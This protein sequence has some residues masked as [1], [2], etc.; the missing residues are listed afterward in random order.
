MVTPF[1]IGQWR[2]GV[3][4]LR[5]ALLNLPSLAEFGR[6]APICKP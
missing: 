6:T 3:A 5:K 2:R 1:D 4:S